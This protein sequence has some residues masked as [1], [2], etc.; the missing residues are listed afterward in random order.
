MGT[1][2]VVIATGLTER[3]A[4]PH[5][6]SHLTAEYGCSVQIRIPPR[7]QPLIPDRVAS[8]M[9]AA[10]WELRGR[11]EAPDKFVVLVDLD[12][13]SAD[14]KLGPF[15]EVCSRLR[16]ITAIRVVASAQWHLEAWFFGDERGLRAYLGRD[17]GS[18]D[19]S[20]PDSITNP[21]L[22]LKN[23]LRVPYT[24]RVAGEISSRISPTVIR[25]KS[26]S[27]SHFEQCVRNGDSAASSMPHVS[28][29][30]PP[31]SS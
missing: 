31:H 2:V 13:A 28:G 27:F 6:L 23:L 25:S 11:G 4:L 5:L 18:V 16:D 26:S 10:W 14:R 9:K 1:R 29:S 22:H 17:L 7:N 24:A 15:K 3:E 8:L 21:K 20:N 12:G 19:A 30:D